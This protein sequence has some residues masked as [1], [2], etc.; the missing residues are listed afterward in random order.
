V[1][2]SKHSEIV[3]LESVMARGW[4]PLEHAWLGRW[5]LRASAGFTGRGNSAL[6]LGDSGRPLSEA[7]DRVES[8]YA[9]HG[10]GAAF[11][12]PTDLDPDAPQPH[13][14]LTDLL[15]GRGY[16]THTPTTVMCSAVERVARADA[17]T[18]NVEIM[19][20]PDDG[21]LALYHYRGQ[22]IPPA[23]HRL[24][25]G[26]AHCRFAAVR[27]AEGVVAIGRVAV[28]RGWAGITAMEVAPSH[29]GRG[30]GRAVLRAL[31][32]YA[33]SVRVPRMY[34]QVADDNR[35]A[36]ALYAGMGFTEHHGY[37]YR[38]CPDR[39]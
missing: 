6:P 32:G 16:T 30:L 37:H 1:S 13:A 39:S 18:A 2:A 7:V 34:L 15:D 27:D 20:R 12:I 17:G 29:R 5:L 35:A 3:R 14:E 36:R 23:G 9:D 38:R 26:S 28:A 11:A 10:I 21:W 25:V 4:W 31:A 33:S 22:Q 24:L 19:T 8:F